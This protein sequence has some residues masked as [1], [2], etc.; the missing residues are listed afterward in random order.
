[1]FRWFLGTIALTATVASASAAFTVTVVPSVGP[2]RSSPDFGQYLQNASYGL[3]AGTTNG[4]V[5]SPNFYA[6]SGTAVGGGAV[7]YL[8]PPL[9]GGVTGLWNGV[10]N[11]T[12]A[13]AGQTGNWV[14]FGLAITSARW[15]PDLHTQSSPIQWSKLSRRC[16]CRP[17]SCWRWR[18][19]ARFRRKLRLYR[20]WRRSDPD[21]HSDNARKQSLLCGFRL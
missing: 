2:D 21:C 1:M 3:H 5:G 18:C 6:P 13:Y 17:C 11:P 16:C 10:V 14:Y 9:G 4:T 7:N 19:V 8:V 12:G 15:R 20:H